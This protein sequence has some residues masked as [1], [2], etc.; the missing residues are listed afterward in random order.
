MK[1]YIHKD[2]LVTNL[3]QPYNKLSVMIADPYKDGVMSLREAI[4]DFVEDTG[5]A[6]EAFC[7]AMRMQQ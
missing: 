1:V 4:R 2:G 6:E 7:E 5:V 3:I